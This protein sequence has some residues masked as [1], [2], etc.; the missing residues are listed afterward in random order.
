MALSA[1]SGS[2]RPSEPI[3]LK[4]RDSGC[5]GRDRTSSCVRNDTTCPGVYHC[6]SDAGDQPLKKR[7]VSDTESETESVTS[8]ADTPCLP[9]V[10]IERDVDTE[11]AAY[12]QVETPC[13]EIPPPT[14][15]TVAIGLSGSVEHVQGATRLSFDNDF[16]TPCVPASTAQEKTRVSSVVSQLAVGGCFPNVLEP[17]A[18]GKLQSTAQVSQF[19]ESAS[20]ACRRDASGAPLEQLLRTKWPDVAQEVAEVRKRLIARGFASSCCLLAVLQKTG[21]EEHRSTARD[22]CC[23]YYKNVFEIQRLLLFPNG[24]ASSMLRGPCVPQCVLPL[25]QGCAEFQDRCSR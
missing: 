19:C 5:G 15:E 16:E 9:T 2:L 14:D 4:S 12:I 21:V 18:S 7:K 17:M 13:I 6:G 3:T 11:S 10:V 22:I 8:D 20:L 24:F 25:E 1:S 23:I